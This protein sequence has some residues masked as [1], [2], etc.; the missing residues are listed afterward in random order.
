ME[1]GGITYTV[2]ART[3]GMLRLEKQIKTSTNKIESDLGRIDQAADNVGQSLQNAGSQA[4]AAGQSMGRMSGIAGNL[5]FQ[6]Q[7]VAIQAQMGTSAFVILGQQGSQIASSF[8]PGGAV[9]GAVLAIASAI[10]GVL[11]TSLKDAG[12]AMNE[13]PAELQAQLEEIKKRFEEVDEASR[14]AFT[15]VELGKLNTQFDKQQKIV[16]DLRSAVAL[17]TAEASKGNQ[18]AAVAAATYA[19]QLKSAE[20]ELINI[21]KL[22]A[23]IGE[24]LASVGIKNSLTDSTKESVSAAESL[25]NQL[26]IAIAKF[27]QGDLAARRMAAAQALGL[28]AA[29]KLPPEIDA[30]LVKL[31]ELEA[32]ERRIA[33]L[34]RQ[35]VEF[36][37]E[38]AQELDREL[39]A[40]LAMLSEKEKA[41]TK[42]AA[43]RAQLASRTQDLGLSP[44][45]QAAARFQRESDLLRQAKEQDLLT[46]QQYQERLATLRQQYESKQGGGLFSTLTDSLAGLQN[47]VSGTFA[48]MA[49]GFEDSDKLAQRLGQTILT[50]LI[51]ATINWGIQQAIAAATGATAT[52]AAEGT[53]A[54][55]ITG[56]AAASAVAST[57]ALGTVTGAAVASGAAI[58]AAMAPAAAATSVATAGAAP[59]AAA[60]IAISSIGAIMAALAGGLALGKMSGRLYG[61]P[62]S[63]G[64]LYPITEDGRP[65]ILQQGNRQ[66][67][68]PGSGGRVISNR[69]MQQAGGGGG[70]L[71]QINNYSGEKVGVTRTQGASKQEIINVVVGNISQRGEIHQAITSNTTAG[72]RTR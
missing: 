51:G 15:Q 34:K 30:A 2:D 64:G 66:Y 72:N 55:A 35:Q 23:R 22:Q 36:Q 37:R 49:L 56:T 18:G 52:V 60:P 68:L 48:Q 27:E 8:G 31:A 13:L 41:Q 47:Q 6:L 28:T 54:A 58:T 67:L 53:K 38:A 32:S 39:Q 14:A 42:A 12:G 29:E 10:G 71:V 1:V 57:A 4:Q 9:F 65:E 11:Y 3:D 40:E 24:E 50:E 25:S 19:L 16:T 43:E 26:A 61:G 63:P 45:Q 17:Y 20:R 70:T 7:D 46:E 69:D 44:E 62:V 59:A 5:G 33:D 21:G